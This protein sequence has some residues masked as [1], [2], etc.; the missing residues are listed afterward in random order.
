MKSL[1]CEDTKGIDDPPK[2]IDDPTTYSQA[3]DVIYFLIFLMGHQTP[4]NTLVLWGKRLIASQTM[5]VGLSGGVVLVVDNVLY[6]TMPLRKTGF[7]QLK[8]NK[9][10]Y[11]LIP[12]V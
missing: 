4:P 12:R 11:Q 10:S 7:P 9:C 8:Q 3:P 2:G 1:A 5:G 6:T